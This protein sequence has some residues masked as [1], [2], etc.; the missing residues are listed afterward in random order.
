[1]NYEFITQLSL[2]A[3]HT[4][5]YYALV[6]C[7]LLFF[8]RLITLNI[9][10]SHSSQYGLLI[11]NTFIFF[12]LIFSFE[13]VL[14][15]IFDFSH[16][17]NATEVLAQAKDR[18]FED[19][20]F[21]LFKKVLGSITSVVYYLAQSLFLFALVFLSGAAPLVFLLSAFLS[22]SSL[23]QIFFFLLMM[24]AT[25][26]IL[27][28]AF[29]QVGLY[30]LKTKGKEEG[31]VFVWSIDFLIELF[32]LLGPLSFVKFLL[33]SHIGKS[34]WHATSMGVRT[35]ATFSQTPMISLEN[36]SLSTFKNK[37]ESFFL[38]SRAPTFHQGFTQQY[39][40]ALNYH[41][42]SSFKQPSTFK[43]QT[44][45]SPQVKTHEPHYNPSK[46]SMN[47]RTQNSQAVSK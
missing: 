29:D 8:A 19:S 3:F 16:S 37:K 31:P 13:Y 34:A 4:T 47:R 39:K 20:D 30:L 27:F 35:V 44:K 7:P 24:G 42:T 23:T 25:W 33:N 36:K 10:A 11:K 22:F 41:N 46:R 43:S 15:L 2:K 28:T 12:V 6:L 45:Y 14:K 26:P 40:R 32:K 17:L 21:S 18:F 1:M 38:R 9:T 5:Q